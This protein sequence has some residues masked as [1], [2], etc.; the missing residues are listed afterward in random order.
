MKISLLLQ[1]EPF[2][3]I[4]AHS[5]ARYLTTT[6]GRS[7]KVRWLAHSAPLAQLARRQS[8]LWLCNPTLNIIY[9]V[10]AQHRVFANPWREFLIGPTP[11][12][13]LAHGL[14][15]GA[16]TAPLGRGLLPSIHLQ[17]EP[18]LDGAESILILGGNSRLRIIDFARKQVVSILKEGFDDRA[19]RREL[20]LRQSAPPPMSP[21][22]LEVRDQGRA[23]VEPLLRAS[24][25]GRM[26]NKSAGEQALQ[27]VTRACASWSQDSE[28]HISWQAWWTRLRQRCEILAGRI[29]DDKEASIAR[30][31]KWIQASGAQ[32]ERLGIKKH[33]LRT[34]LSHGDLQSG[35]IL[36]EN[37]RPWL[38]DW[39]SVDRRVLDYDA[40]TL[41][42]GPRYRVDG[43]MQR[44]QKLARKA[45]VHSDSPHR[46]DKEA[47]R[48][49]LLYLL[50]E[51]KFY[52]EESAIGPLFGPT[53]GTVAF[54]R[55]LPAP[56]QA[57]DGISAEN[58]AT[59][60]EF[61]G[62]NDAD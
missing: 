29:A 42:L 23:F 12:S 59:M 22:I 62:N 18:E 54:V 11:L 56:P 4:F 32:L 17:I 33:G 3:Q 58:Q 27:K 31:M 19:F 15:L 48:R 39:E 16:N 24:S 40:W 41:A 35:N 7:H 53:P 50:E 55:G 1:R 8:G 43:R 30:L 5:L 21:S 9:S 28:E 10:R 2:K 14:Y 49:L 25:A 52:L 57:R 13:T 38:I 61:M 34:A 20:R 60:S 37:K 26:L 36:I 44:L 45:S 6:T 46:D 47:Q 51:A